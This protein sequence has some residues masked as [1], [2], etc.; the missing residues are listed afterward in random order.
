MEDGRDGR[1]RATEYAKRNGTWKR[2]G[3]EGRI[4]EKGELG[5]YNGGVKDLA[6]AYVL[7]PRLAERGGLSIYGQD[8]GLWNNEG[9]QEAEL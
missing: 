6:S 2:G 3:G 1:I 5:T 7:C 4:E 9:I 8:K